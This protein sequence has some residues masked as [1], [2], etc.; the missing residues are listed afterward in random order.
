MFYFCFSCPGGHSS[1]VPCD[2]GKYNDKVGQTDEAACKVLNLIF[3]YLFLEWKR[4]FQQRCTIH[5]ISDTCQYL[6][7]L[8]FFPPE[9]ALI[10]LNLVLHFIEKPVSLCIANQMTRFCMKC[11]TRLEWIKEPLNK[12]LMMLLISSKNSGLLLRSWPDVIYSNTWGFEF[13]TCVFV[14]RVC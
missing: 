5:L 12:F 2:V 13:D 4:F 3:C 9:W 1:A 8:I 14:R 6:K 7:A 10:Y 11:N